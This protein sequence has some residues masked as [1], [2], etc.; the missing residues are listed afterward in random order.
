VSWPQHG[1]DCLVVGGGLAG[2]VAALRLAAAG[3]DVLLVERE[4]GPHHKVCGEFLSPEAVHYLVAAGVDPALGAEPIHRL[5]VSAGSRTVAVDL[6]FPALSLS[7]SALDEAL[8]ARAAEQGC[9]I[10]RGAGVESL[11]HVGGSWR[12]LLA[13][14]GGIAADH[15]FLATGKHD[16]RGWARPPGRQNDLVGFK[17]HY[18][19]AP[20]QVEALRGVMELFLFRGGYGGLSLVESGVANLCLV[21]RRAELRRLGGWPQLMRSLLGKD[22]ALRQRLEDAQ[23][24]WE[25]PLAI[26]SIPYGYLAPGQQADEPQLWPVGDQI[27]VIPSFTGDG[28]SIALHS[29]TLAAECF[30]AGET[31]AE[32]RQKLVAQLQRGMTLAT[33]LSR[34]MV[35]SAGRSLA[36][37][38]LAMAPGIL[39]SIA[40][41]TRIPAPALLAAAQETKA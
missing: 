24:V 35:T 11:A 3:R 25:R 33:G 6:P 13:D 34:L 20:A 12:A 37:P 10:L 19:L 14:G 15:V 16:L 31:P 9:R 36:P 26:S 21:V 5:R 1:A 41:R 27:A 8:L 32:Y 40:L 4:R 39:R 38:V 22:R 17:L 29:A 23:P 7:R 18:R 30:L 28:M 2:P